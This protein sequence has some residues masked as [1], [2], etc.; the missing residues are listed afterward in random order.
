MAFPVYVVFRCCLCYLVFIVV[1]IWGEVFVCLLLLGFLVLGVTFGC[2]FKHVFVCFCLHDCLLVLVVYVLFM[3]CCLLIL[4]LVCVWLHCM[5][6]FVFS[7]CFRLVGCYLQSCVVLVLFEVCIC[8]IVLL[9][10]M[11]GLWVA[12]CLFLLCVFGVVVFFFMYVFV[13]FAVVV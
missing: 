13:S 4:C 6:A 10:H 8:L 11:I 1:V 2:A 3:A 5:G 7:R 12:V 9:V